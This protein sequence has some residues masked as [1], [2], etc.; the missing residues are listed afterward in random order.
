MSERRD[1]GFTLIE[2]LVS[3]AILAI[4]FTVLFGAIS[5]SLDRARKNRDDA[6]ATSLVQSLLTSA[7][8]T[9]NL[10]PG[11]TTGVYSN[12]FHWRLA[13]RPYG[14]ADDAKA[15]KLSAHVVRATVSWP[16][17]AR[18]LSALRLIPPPAKPP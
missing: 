11:E 4:A 12:G 14:N 3:L 13:V 8:A 10:T 7:G 5:Q 9:K 6:V 2:L 16:G 1:R 18:S 15:W 17:G